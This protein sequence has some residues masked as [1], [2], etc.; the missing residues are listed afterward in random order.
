MPAIGHNSPTS[1]DGANS[2]SIARRGTV[3][4]DPFRTLGGA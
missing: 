4:F 2:P 3:I 1:V